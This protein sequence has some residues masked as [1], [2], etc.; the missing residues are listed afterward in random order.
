V[1]VAVF[2]LGA[3][4]SGCSAHTQV[5]SGSPDAGVSV[6]IDGGRGLAAVL[7][8]SALAAGIYSAEW[9]SPSREAP[10]L[11]PTRRVSE[12]DCSKPID[13]TLGN[14]RCK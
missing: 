2:L 7:G 14:I 11:D 6:Q 12:Q 3:L 10:E 13:Y 9:G 5:R 1:R 4:L 8:L